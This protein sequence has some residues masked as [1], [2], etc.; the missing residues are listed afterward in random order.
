M[1]KIEKKI[2]PEYFQAIVDGKKKFELRIADFKINEGDVLVLREWNSNTKKY[3]GRVLEKE[4]KFVI[5]TKDLNFFNKDEI[6][7][8]GFQIMSFD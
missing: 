5:K 1:K 8:Y 6:E 4:V 3:T 7:D 2:W